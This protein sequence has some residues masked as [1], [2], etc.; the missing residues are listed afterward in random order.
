MLC[1]IW[2]FHGSDYEECRLLGYRNPVLTSQE[3]HNVSATES[4]RLMLCKIW[5]FHGGGYEECRLLGYKNSFHTSQE[6]HYVSPTESSRLM[7]CTIWGF[8]GVD[9]EEGRLLGCDGVWLFLEPT[10]RRTI[11]IIRVE[12]FSDLGTTLAV[13]RNRSTLRKE[14]LSSFSLLSF[15]CYKSHTASHPRRRHSSIRNWIRFPYRYNVNGRN[16]GRCSQTR[17]FKTRA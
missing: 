17:P 10:F 15:G 9:C 16:T 14:I 2:G 1:K 8:Q 6:T 13:N 12:I 3:T 7:L 11:A 4:S 5:G